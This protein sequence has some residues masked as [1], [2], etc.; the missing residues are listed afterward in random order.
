MAARA[1]GDADVAFA[2]GVWADDAGVVDACCFDGFGRIKKKMTPMIAAKI[3]TAPMARSG[4]GLKDFAAATA[5]S[6]C[7]GA[8]IGKGGGGIAGAA[9]DGVGA[10]AGMATAGVAGTTAGVAA[11]GE[12]SVTTSL[13]VTSTD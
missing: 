9:G 10:V 8:A 2:A 5:R 1:G 4:Q 11:R 3:T 12:S 6:F 13:P 7:A